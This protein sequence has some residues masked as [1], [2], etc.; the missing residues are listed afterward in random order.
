M[1]T[2][3]Y[4]MRLNCQWWKT[5]KKW[6]TTII[7]LVYLT[8][9]FYFSCT[10]KTWMITALHNLL[11]FTVVFL[12][13]IL[14]TICCHPFTYNDVIRSFSLSLLFIYPVSVKFS[15]DSFLVMSQKWQI[16]LFLILIR[17][18]I[19]SIIF[20]INLPYCAIVMSMIFFA[21]FPRLLFLRPYHSFSSVRKIIQ[22]K[23]S[24]REL[25]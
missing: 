9:H 24:Y 23:V 15:K 4:Q 18:L 25:I 5:T 19:F 12:L 7:F 11:S 6:I 1:G 22:H 21:L 20:S 16:S 17:N 2:I 14:P 8:L 3:P 13:I 10:F